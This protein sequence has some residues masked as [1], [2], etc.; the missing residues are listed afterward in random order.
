MNKLA[1][2]FV[3]KMEQFLLMTSLIGK[4]FKIGANKT[5]LKNWRKMNPVE[6]EI[7]EN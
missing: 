6:N 1:N 5:F 7:D 3:R 4:E 2:I